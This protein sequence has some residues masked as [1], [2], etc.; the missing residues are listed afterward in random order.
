[1]DLAESWI[2]DGTPRSL[3]EA[4][5]E[6]FRARCRAAG[7][8]YAAAFEVYHKLVTAQARLIISGEAFTPDELSR[9]RVARAALELAR[10]DFRDWFWA[11]PSGSSAAKSRC[12]AGSPAN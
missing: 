4:E 2:G 3:S 11:S 7:E 6:A 10:A 12:I 5:I 9:T 1:V 8:R